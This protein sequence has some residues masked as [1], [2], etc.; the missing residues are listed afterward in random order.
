ML[1]PTELTGIAFYSI[2]VHEP[3]SLITNIAI[4]LVSF[5]LY[6]RSQTRPL[7]SFQSYWSYFILCIG[8]GALGGMIVH[9]FPNLLSEKAFFIL[10]ASKNSFIAIANYFAAMAMFTLIYRKPAKLPGI[11]FLLKSFA[12]IAFLFIT[13]SF[14]PA[15]ID[16]SFTYF[17]VLIVTLRYASNREDVLSIRNAFIVALLSGPIFLLG[18]DLGSIMVHTQGYITYFR[19]DQP[20]VNLPGS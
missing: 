13:N 20:L 10:M 19:I 1:Y 17:F 8:I 6:S 9:G 16:L 12:V 11:L 18:Y 7:S 3:G 15:V 14:T 4:V 2:Y 5:I